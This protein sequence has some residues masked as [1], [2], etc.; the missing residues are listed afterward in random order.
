MNTATDFWKPA[1]N[2][3]KSLKSENE[4]PVSLVTINQRKT[5]SILKGSDNVIGHVHKTVK[6]DY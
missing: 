4:K 1:I 3:A 5:Q 2:T 6:S